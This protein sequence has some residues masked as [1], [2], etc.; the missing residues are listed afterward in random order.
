MLSYCLLAGISIC[1]LVMCLMYLKDNDIFEDEVILKFKRLIMVL[2]VEVAV[3]SVF[4]L[5]E[6]KET[7][8]ELLYILKAGELSMNLVLAY[9]VF[10][11]FYDERLKT[12]NKV[13]GMLWCVMRL[14]V[15]ASVVLQIVGVF[16]GAVFFLDESNV[17][18]R[19]SYMWLYLVILATAI[20]M[21]VL[22]IVMFSNQTQGMMKATLAALSS[23]LALGILLREFFPRMNYDFLCMVASVTFM[24]IYYSN[25]TLRIDPL[26]QLLN[27]LVYETALKRIK[28]TTV[29]IVFDANK[30]KKINDEHG[31][32]RGDKALKQLAYLIRKT[33]GEM[34]YCFRQ[35][36]DEFCVI[37][38]KGVFDKLVAESPDD[39]DAYKVK[40]ML[41]SKIDEALSEHVKVIN[42]AKNYL[43]YGVARGGWI[44]YGEEYAG[45]VERMTMAQVAAKADDEM[46]EQKR[47]MKEEELAKAKVEAEAE[48]KV[49]AEAEAKAENA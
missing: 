38:K 16:T 31:H 14:L 10:D 18:H 12:R 11:I 4:M 9:L 6:G 26:T 33:Y 46:Y 35:G 7:V 45:D 3:D 36:G 49:E 20:L 42:Q 13:A 21:V 1:F 19:G 25:V 32:K 2:M 39:D 40:E 15:V 48:A 8:R 34:A 5:L 30:F 24:L 44:Y 28:Y 17:Y 22:E 29:V 27:R 23:V 47:K 41:K 37:L 43:K